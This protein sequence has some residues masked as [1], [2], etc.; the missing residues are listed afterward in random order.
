MCLSLGG[1][2]LSFFTR[3]VSIENGLEVFVE[4]LNYAAS[5]NVAM[6]SPNAFY[7][8]CGVNLS[9]IALELFEYCRTR[10]HGGKQTPWDRFWF[11]QVSQASSNPRDAKPQ[12]TRAH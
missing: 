1:A 9:M 6:G 11:G 4:F 10:R 3:W 2:Q 12:A 8:A 7:V 5:V